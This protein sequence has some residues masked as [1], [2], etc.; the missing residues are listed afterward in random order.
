MQT[1]RDCEFLEV[2]TVDVKDIFERVRRV[3]VQVRGVGFSTAA[4]QE[5][6]LRDELLELFLDVCYFLLRKLVFVEQNSRF[7]QVLQVVQLRWQQEQ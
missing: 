5:V 6:V 4:V 2:Q 3:C 7:S 1:E